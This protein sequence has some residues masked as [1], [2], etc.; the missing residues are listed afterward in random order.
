MNMNTKITGKL[1]TLFL[2]F[3]VLLSCTNYAG[4]KRGTETHITNPILPG[5]FADP[6]I[7]KDNG[8]FYI[9]ATED[10]WG[11]DSLGV[12]ETKDFVSFTRRHLNWPTKQACTSSTS[13]D[14]KVWA[15]SVVKG[16]DGKFHMFVSVGSEVWAGVADGPLGPWKNSR[17][18][19][20]PLVRYD[21]FKEINI[22]NIDADAFVDEDGTAYLYWGS[23]FH[24]INGHCLAA[25][26]T[27]DMNAFDGKPVEVTPPHY[28]EG[29]H[30]IKRKRK[31]YLMFSEGKAINETYRIG[32]A[33]GS[34][35]F[36]PFT[37]GAN[38]PILKTIPNTPTIGPGHHTVFN[39]KG[40][41]YILYHRIYPQA[42]DY[43]L[44]Q[45]CV[46]SLKF[47]SYENILPVTPRGISALH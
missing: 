43:V 32:Y 13:H 12:F 34:S 18:D 24:W 31:Y 45:L 26:L 3:A 6:T 20:S 9:Y 42:K 46:D 14:S 33:V 8:F 35:P 17:P 1:F 2:L 36:G 7:I 41:D 28:F 39:E 10:P 4:R 47:D 15:P 21:D 29:P 25:K 40:Q 27:A 30:M 37:E 23:G 5:Y 11:G 16:A 22:H 19:N 44:R 38:S